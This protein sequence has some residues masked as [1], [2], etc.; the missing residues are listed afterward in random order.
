MKLVFGVLYS[1][2]EKE[3]IGLCLGGGAARGYALIPIL[4]KMLAEGIRPDALSGCSIGAVVGAYYCLHGEV[5]TLMEKVSSMRK[6]DF[7]ALIDLNNP[8]ESLIKGEKMRKF[9]IDELFGDATFDDL[10]I[11]LSVVATDIA[12]YTPTYFTQG[13]LVDALMASSTI[14]GILPPYSINGGLYIDG[15]VTKH[16]P[17][18]TLFRDM[19]MDRVV[20]IDLVSGVQRTIAHNEKTPGIFDVLFGSFYSLL[21]TAKIEDEYSNYVFTFVPQW[22]NKKHADTIKFH[23]IDENLEPGQ[24]VLEEEWGSFKKWMVGEKN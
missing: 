3:K 23:R 16:I 24:K 8:R 20:A 18:K 4:Q 21:R 2:M 12:S 17:Y 14:P 9:F 11:P 6:R 22:P 19:N 15:G 5:D 7:I 13:K 10:Q 1:T